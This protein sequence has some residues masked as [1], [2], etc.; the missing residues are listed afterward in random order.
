MIV[1][2]L[3]RHHLDPQRAIARAG[4]P[5]RRALFLDRDGVINVNH[6]YVHRPEQT[7]WLP[8]IFELCRA[9]RAA[10]FVLVVVTNQAGIARGLYT[11]EQFL[12]YTRWVH[13][14]FRQN[15]APL[16]ATFYCPHHPD[17]GVGAGL[18][19]CDCRKPEPGMLLSAARL[20]GLDLANS[21]LLGD[22]E[23]DTQ[24]AAAAGVGRAFLLGRDLQSPDQLIGLARWES[25]L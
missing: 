1:T 14:Q 21:L 24:A 6:G 12:E 7:Q 23:S 9:A 5:P 4:A 17:A 10:G 8:G 19:D 13:A 11:E 22:T 20:L 25:R 16:E 3:A 18:I 2:T 15:G